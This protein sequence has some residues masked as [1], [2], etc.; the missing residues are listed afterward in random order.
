MRVYWFQSCPAGGFG[1]E[2]VNIK[3]CLIIENISSNQS[4]LFVWVFPGLF[5]SG[6]GFFLIIIQSYIQRIITAL[7]L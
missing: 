2:N 4:L 1:L 5:S 3:K 6:E 7:F